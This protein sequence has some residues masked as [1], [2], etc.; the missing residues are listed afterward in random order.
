MIR[1]MIS[2]NGLLFWATLYIKD[3]LLTYVLIFLHS[4]FIL[5]PVTSSTSWS[6]KFS[7]L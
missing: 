2:D 7:V 1:I 6:L 4:I 5:H 3:Y